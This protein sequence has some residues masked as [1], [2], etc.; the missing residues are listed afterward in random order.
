MR[1][2][3]EPESVEPALRKVEAALARHLEEACEG[4]DQKDISKESMDELLRLEEELFAAA[5]AAVQAVR[6]RRQLGERAAGEQSS[7]TSTGP[8]PELPSDGGG[9]AYRVREFKDYAGREWRVWQVSP[10]SAARANSERYLGQYFKGWLAFELLQG[11]LRKRL[12]SFPEDWL[13]MSDEQL[14]RLLGS[15]A[16]VLP[17]KARSEGGE[18]PP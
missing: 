11:D 17:R 8:P 6:L 10:R 16:D 15:A 3:H 9:T 1:T 18:L 5:R 7:D 12:P 13:G 4:V 14:N 2:P